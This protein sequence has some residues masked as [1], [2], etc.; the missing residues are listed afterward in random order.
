MMYPTISMTIAPIN[1]G[2]KAKNASR[3]VRRDSIIYLLSL[4]FV[5]RKVRLCLPLRP[6]GADPRSPETAYGPTDEREEQGQDTGDG[7]DGAE[8]LLRG[9]LLGA[10]LRALWQRDAGELVYEAH[11]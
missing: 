6:A 7:Q 3:P 8:P 4:V 5:G 9:R 11:P 10:L 2:R 1:W